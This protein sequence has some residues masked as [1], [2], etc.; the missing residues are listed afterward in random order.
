[1]SS[2]LGFADDDRLTLCSSETHVH[3]HRFPLQPQHASTSI[4]IAAYFETAGSGVVDTHLIEDSTCV[5]RPEGPDFSA[6]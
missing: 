4:G 1:M 6:E 2:G 5:D 3:H